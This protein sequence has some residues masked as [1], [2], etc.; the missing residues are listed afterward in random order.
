M[1]VIIQPIIKRFILKPILAL[2]AGFLAFISL[3]LIAACILS[4]IPVN[5]NDS[6]EPK[7]VDVYIASNGVHTDIVLPLQHQVMDWRQLMDG[8]N[9]A[10]MDTSLAYIGI[11]WGDRGFYLETPTW[12]DLKLSTA[13]KAAFSLN[14]TAMHVTFQ[15]QPKASGQVRKL[16][17]SSATYQKLVGQINSSFQKDEKGYFKV[18]NG[19]SYGQNDMFFEA[20][21]SYN[22]FNTCNA[23]T[24]GVLKAAGLRAS[25]WSP[26][27]KGIL[28]Q[29][30]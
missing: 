3:Y 4:I 6:S 20:H 11:G 10:T 1:R 29:H 13:F 2:V 18:I 15:K 8:S 25:V 27:D 28:F 16:T 7:E 22:M 9:T 19:F 23:W 5:T 12:P 26:F 14:Q 21:G 30:K 17:V 24:N